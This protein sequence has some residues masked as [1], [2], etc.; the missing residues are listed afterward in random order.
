M[1][2]GPFVFQCD[3]VIL[4]DYCGVRWEACTILQV[5]VQGQLSEAVS[6]GP[7]L[8]GSQLSKTNANL[9]VI[10]CLQSSHCLSTEDPKTKVC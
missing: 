3:K 7:L 4:C 8:H 1:G 6:L 10:H 9:Q 2:W 5:E